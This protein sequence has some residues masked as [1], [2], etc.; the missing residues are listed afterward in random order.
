MLATDCSLKGGI[1][2]TRFTLFLMR[3]S[4]KLNSTVCFVRVKT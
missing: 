1:F 4:A 2:F 3:H